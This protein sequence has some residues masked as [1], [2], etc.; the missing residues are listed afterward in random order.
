[1]RLFQ[2]AAKGVAIEGVAIAHD[3]PWEVRHEAGLLNGVT[4]LETKAEAL[5]RPT[6][7]SALYVRL[8]VGKPVAIPL[9]LVPYYAWGNRGQSQMTVWLP[10]IWK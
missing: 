3:C 1:M 7:V 10:V 8:P 9:R 4:A 6:D 5:P 2:Q